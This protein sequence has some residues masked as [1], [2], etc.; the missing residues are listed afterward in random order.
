MSK[1]PSATLSYNTPWPPQ[2]DLV[3]ERI[4]EKMMQI[5]MGNAK[6]ELRF[7]ERELERLQDMGLDDISKYA[8]K[9]FF[10]PRAVLKGSNN[11]MKKM[12]RRKKRR[13]G[14][15]EDGD[16]L[17]GIKSPLRS[18]SGAA[19][20]LGAAESEWHR[21]LRVQKEKEA[22]ERQLMARADAEGRQFNIYLLEQDKIKDEQKFVYYAGKFGPLDGLTYV[23]STR[24]G[25]LYESILSDA[26]RVV[27]KWWRDIGPQRMLRK[28]EAAN[29]MQK[30]YR[31]RKGRETFVNEQ[32][33]KKS[34]KK[35]FNRVAS[36]AMEQWRYQ[37]RTRKGTRRLLR[38]RLM[39]AKSETFEAWSD[40]VKEIVKHRNENI[41]PALKRIKL[42][43]TNAAWLKWIELHE[44]NLQIKRLMRRSF[45][46]VKQ[47]FFE[48]WCDRVEEIVEEK[49]RTFA[50]RSDKATLIQKT[51][52]GQH[53]RNHKVRI[54]QYKRN[55]YVNEERRDLNRRQVR[56]NHVT[57]QNE[58]VLR[59][60]RE[61]EYVDKYVKEEAK[62][63]NK[64]IKTRRWKKHFAKN[65]K[66][67]NENKEREKWL[68]DAHIE[69]IIEFR[70][71]DP[72]FTECPK[73]LMSFVSDTLFRSHVCEHGNNATVESNILIKK[74]SLWEPYHKE[75]IEDE[76]ERRNSS[77]GKR[78]MKRLR[79]SFSISGDKK[80]RRSMEHDT[81]FM[82]RGNTNASI[83]QFADDD[84]ED[85][86]SSTIHTTEHN[87]DFPLTIKRLEDEIQT[88]K[89]EM[90]TI[91]TKHNREIT[92][93]KTQLRS[94]HQDKIKAEESAMESK[95]LMEK[96]LRQVKE[97]ENENS[98]LGGKVPKFDIEKE[99]EDEVAAKQRQSLLE[100]ESDDETK[101]D[102]Q[103][104]L[105]QKSK[106]TI[107][108]HL[109]KS[110]L[111]PKQ[112][113]IMNSKSKKSKPSARGN[114]V[115]IQKIQRPL[116]PV[117]RETMTYAATE[118]QKVA[119]GW[120]IRKKPILQ[121]GD[122]SSDSGSVE[123]LNVSDLN[124]T[125]KE[126]L[127]VT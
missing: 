15:G 17:P 46:G 86:V 87:V 63:F 43:R 122:F 113:N 67:Y 59:L 81:G 24:P 27:Q 123:Q 116:T 118:I 54:K 30:L 55:N 47:Y 51:W 80:K 33:V 12:K 57:T 56:H 74:S 23:S 82:I 49:A 40:L 104:A 65:M 6:T 45:S 18:P 38:N 64:M 109:G 126:L 53:D 92:M 117:D 72:P 4:Q 28:Q 5:K 95:K 94:S 77:R 52:R 70:E 10:D 102:L 32:K 124:S 103:R 3:E 93:M 105:Y 112:R 106:S 35:L 90:K 69:A 89:D 120:N 83:I 68:H 110:N 121:W 85:D 76:I 2:N 73:C 16:V 98:R 99:I 37:V 97:L 29:F 31:G 61:Q 26:C 58:E 111:K 14:G 50:M 91:L 101:R 62:N 79:K 107:G 88:Q 20:M 25:R 108:S 1:P 7:L 115:K 41:A 44:Q 125:K 39:G 71:T 8:G 100:S 9:R 42:R 75:L 13:G 114:I 34:L 66:N 119:R 22:N 48:L 19:R 84:E 11:K 96:L 127:P 21:R 60:K 36:A 78:W